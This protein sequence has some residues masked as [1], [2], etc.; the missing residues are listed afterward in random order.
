MNKRIVLHTVGWI[1]ELE[2]ILLAAPL[3]V[4]L[5]YGES[6]SRNAFLIVMGITA[7]IGGLLLL[8]KPKVSNIYAREGFAIVALSWI[9]MSL[10]VCLPFVISGSIPH[11]V[12]AFFETVSGFTTTGA[13]ILTDV[14]ALDRSMLF[15]RS[16]THWVGGMGVLVFVMVILPLGGGSSMHLL[17]A[18]S[19]GPVSGKLVPKMHGTA[20][21]LYGIY[22][23]MTLLLVV[24]LWCGGMPIYDCLI[25][26]FGTA[27]TGG[28]SNWG[29]SIGH[30]NREFFEVVIGVFM[31]L[32]GVNFNLYYLLLMR[33][34]KQVFKSEELKV[35]L[36]IVVFAVVTIALNIHHLY[37]S[38]HEALR[39]SFF[40]VSTILTTTGF[41][42]TDFNQWPQYAKTILVLLMLI[43][44]CAGSTAGG[45]K[46]S[47]VI[48]LVKAA[49]RG[50]KKMIHSRSMEV[51]NFEHKAVE[52]ETVRNCSV[53][54]CI[55]CL[56][57]ILSVVLISLDDFSF[58]TNVTGTIAC[59][60]NIGPGLDLVGPVGNYAMY[61]W[62]SK[63]VLSF[64]MLAGRLE[65]FPL[66]ILFLP[67]IWRRG[68]HSRHG[69]GKH[70][71][72]PKMHTLQKKA[73]R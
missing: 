44:A 14:E 41:A 24:I 8:W 32:F 56:L 19:P 18:E 57:A 22:L 67:G 11:F 3:I 52:E 50:V 48:L 2:A 47:R 25:N 51:V 4:S 72:L 54:L 46:I 66:L 53:Y 73:V 13:S 1:M 65:L 37:Q 29:A 20:R 23:A 15:W 12:D 45:L 64:D 55:Y 31:L 42:T 17:R 6:S 26:A 36:G 21:I 16:F 60:N 59:L 38:F 40:Q 70:L 34:V 43:G 9:L 28:F 27:G 39:Y 62:F 68:P 10:F 71:S 35:Y 33:K 5:I 49:R 7:A 61:S 30:Y 69:H 63:L 58:E